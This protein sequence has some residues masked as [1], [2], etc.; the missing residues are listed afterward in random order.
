MDS[1]YYDYAWGKKSSHNLV[2]EEVER[3]DLILSLIPQDCRTILD[4]GC[5]DGRVTNRLCVNYPKV[6]GLDI[7]EKALK[8]IA[9]ETVIG[10]AN[11]LPFRDQSFDLILCSETLEHI[12]SG[13]YQQVLTEIERVS[14]KYIL[15]TVP[16]NENLLQS[17][18]I[19]PACGHKFHPSRHARSFTKEDMLHLFTKF[20]L[21]PMQVERIE[22]VAITY[23]KIVI[24][25][26]KFLGV[27]PRI[28]YFPDAN[29]CPNCGYC[30]PSSPTTDKAARNRLWEWL[31]PFVKWIIV[32]HHKS[33]N[34]LIGLYNRGELVFDSP[35][36]GARWAS[37]HAPYFDITKP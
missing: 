4:I 29:Y 24:R 17:S 25:I 2:S 35:S 10:S 27:I 3:I 32:R 5:G 6:V 14:A 33:W 22:S 37:Y 23:P 36:S 31:V 1:K 9:T 15:V 26:A 12:P 13:T 28:D 30:T 19:C 34:L 21:R 7:S 8:H 16:N 20:R 11:G 18:I